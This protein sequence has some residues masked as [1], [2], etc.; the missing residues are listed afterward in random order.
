MYSEL[1][2]LNLQANTI[3]SYQVFIN[4]NT[5]PQP[6]AWPVKDH[7]CSAI[8]HINTACILHY[9]FHQNY[10]RQNRNFDDFVDMLLANIKNNQPEVRMQCFT[11]YKQLTFCWELLLGGHQLELQ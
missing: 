10:H 9:H 8:F 11:P 1:D 3:Y 6:S 7:S 5:V 4:T 2:K